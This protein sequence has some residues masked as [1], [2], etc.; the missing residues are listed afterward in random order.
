MDT[1]NKIRNDFP[2]GTEGDDQYD[3]YFEE[4]EEMIEVLLQQNTS[5]TM[6]EE[7]IRVM[8]K[9]KTEKRNTLNEAGHRKEE[10]E[11]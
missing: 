8:R 10:R 6:Q 3:D 7:T 2:E 5:T 9:L 11:E 1:Y 4:I